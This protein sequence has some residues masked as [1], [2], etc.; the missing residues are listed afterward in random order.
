VNEKTY[1]WLLVACLLLNVVDAGLTLCA[2]SLGVLEANPLMA[3]AL[4][5]GPSFF[6][7]V[8]ISL[9]TVAAVFLYFKRPKI[10]VPVTAIYSMVFVYH[11]L[12]WFI[13]F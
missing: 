4:S 12:F 1:A 2:I 8:K 6:L 13:G 7:A 3:Y 11:S 10:L 5:Y 9:F